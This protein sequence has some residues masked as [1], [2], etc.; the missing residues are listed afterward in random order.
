MGS[1]S[2]SKART[3]QNLNKISSPKE[4][5]KNVLNGFHKAVEK[6]SGK[7]SL[8]IKWMKFLS[9]EEPAAK[10]AEVRS[11]CG[12]PNAA[13]N[14]SLKNS[15]LVPSY[16]NYSL[17]KHIKSV[18]KSQRPKAIP[19][20]GLCV[21]V[22]PDGRELPFGCVEAKRQG[23]GKTSN[24]TESKNPDQHELE[25]ME[26]GLG[27]GG[28]GNALERA[29]KNFNLYVDW[30]ADQPVTGYFLFCEGPAFKKRSTNQILTG[31]SGYDSLN[32]LNVVDWGRKCAS[33]FVKC[34]DGDWWTEDE[35]EGLLYKGLEA[36]VLK[37]KEIYDFGE[38]KH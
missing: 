28:A 31:I 23:F 17:Q 20:G 12:D 32:R 18:K 33:V 25:L 29:Y 30:T 34:G 14:D 15:G 27:S 21:I 10:L 26:M 7:Y 38:E 5:E 8:K 4:L 13:L 22:L 9:V 16:F 37:Y 1:E 6:L 36:I 24:K 3:G 35:I 2:L 11:A 19:D